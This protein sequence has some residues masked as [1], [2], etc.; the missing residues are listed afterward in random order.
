ML[1][2]VLKF[3]LFK[4]DPETIHEFLLKILSFPGVPCFLKFLY[5]SDAWN[6]PVDYFG[7]RFK[8]R[9]GLAAGFDKNGVALKAWE[10]LGFGF[11]EIGTVTP[12]P[13]SGNPKPRLF[14]F[15]AQHALVNAMGF[16]NEGIE[17]VVQRIQKAKLELSIGLSI[18]KNKDTPL[19]DAWKDYVACIQV[20]NDC[21]DFFVVNISSPNTPQL[22]ELQK[23]KYLKELL[24]KILTHA[25]RPLLLKLSPDLSDSEI[26]DIMQICKPLSLSG[27]V[28]SNT[29]L[30]KK[31]Q[32]LGA[33]GGATEA[34]L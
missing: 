32:I 27:F 24:E 16:N 20:A 13:Q 5:G 30:F 8:N 25:R 28:A 23:P 18:G 33:R 10:A 34:Y 3:F 11:V 6:S 15:S 31:A 19:I 22:R 4:F 1:Y 9:V 12:R 7:V 21:V 2:K 17:R 26:L 29:G 14:R